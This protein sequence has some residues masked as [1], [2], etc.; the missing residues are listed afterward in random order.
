MAEVNAAKPLSF[1]QSMTR[2]EQIVVT[3][4]R[5]ECEL[6]QSLKL[7]EEGAQLAARC[8]KMLDEA[9]QKVNILLED[10]KEAP[11]QAEG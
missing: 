2:L 6:E 7:F 9:E 4:E 11:F 3:L 10:G 8:E 1:E 5:G